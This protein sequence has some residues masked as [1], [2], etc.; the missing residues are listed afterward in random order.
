MH[1]ELYEDGTGRLEIIPTPSGSPSLSNLVPHQSFT[2]TGNN[3]KGTFEFFPGPGFFLT[4]NKYCAWRNAVWRA[5]GVQPVI[6]LR[7]MRGRALRGK[8]QGFA[9]AVLLKH[10]F[11]LSHAPDIYTCV[12]LT[13]GN[14]EVIDVHYELPY[15]EKLAPDFPL[16]DAFVNEIH[17][18]NAFDASPVKYYCTLG[19]DNIIS[20]LM[21][22]PFDAVRQKYLV[23]RAAY[24]LLLEALFAMHEQRADYAGVTFT[25]FETEVIYEAKRKIE[26]DDFAVPLNG[27]LAHCGVND[28]KLNAGFKKF[29]GTT[30]YK[31]HM[32]HK[33]D[34]AVF[35][36]LH[37]TDTVSE[38]AYALNYSLPHHFTAEFTKRF[39]CPPTEYRRR[40]RK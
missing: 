21:N 17:R 37:T 5:M 2:A 34:I 26:H 11:A 23:E 16:L 3:A 32:K 10:Q 29:F 22:C 36:L 1:L 30:P 18:G 40:H 14:Y 27:L 35:R 4:Y 25:Q 19:M 20:G 13:P 28:H 6:E 31:C 39:E 9:D 7:I 12:N 38:I 33:M 15:L 24:D 8:W